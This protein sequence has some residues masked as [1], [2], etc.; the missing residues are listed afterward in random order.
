M[1]KSSSKREIVLI[2]CI[3]PAFILYT[4]FVIGPALSSIY[5]SLTQWDGISQSTMKFIGVQNFVEI[6]SSSRFYRA[7][8]HTFFIAFF[9]TIVVNIISLLLALA[10]DNLRIGKNIFRSAFYV[11]VLISGVI[12]GFIWAIMFNYSFGVI[13]SVLHMLHLDF[14]KTD[15]LGKSPNALI[16]LIIPLVWHLSGYYM[17]IYLAGLQGIPNE[18]N[19]ASK[20]DGVN[21]WQHFWYITFPLMAGSM[22]VNLTL[23]LIS[24]LKVF[25][26]IAVMTDGGPGF[27]TETITYLI[28]RVAFAELRQGFGTAL[29]MTLFVIILVFATFQVTYLR[30][31]EVQL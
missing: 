18:L 4:A 9:F 21:R 29:A 10:V 22:T 25:D 14:L 8:G 11:P 12:G 15:W 24:G 5:L 27:A 28:Y 1:I 19:E 17:V 26:Q 30:K 20:I 7:L 16:S 31:R 13:N 23:A 3:L 2:M 6:F